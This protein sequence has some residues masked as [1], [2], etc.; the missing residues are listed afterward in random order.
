MTISEDRSR[1]VEVEQSVVLD[2]R[3][4]LERRLGENDIAEA[5]R[6]EDRQLGRVVI[7][8][9]LHPELRADPLVL[10][11][12]R[13]E[14]LAAAQL[15][16]GHVAG[17]FDVAVHDDVA[18]TVGEY[19]DGPSLVRL[20]DDGPL[21]PAVVAAVGH[22][23]ASGLA[24]AHEEGIIHRD[25]RPGNLLVGRDGRV[26]IVDFGSARIPD[27]EHPSLTGRALAAESYL[28]PE[29]ATGALSTDRS[30]VYALGRTLLKA[31]DGMHD[32]P[33]DEDGLLDRV[34]GSIPGL[35]LGT[36]DGDR[37]R[38]EIAAAMAPD[39]ARRPTA[40]AFADALGRLYGTRGDEVLRRMIADVG[41]DDYGPWL[42]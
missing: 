40:A 32:V 39:P 24:A 29:L 11:R 3:F 17:I 41:E 12:F 14:A 6:A 15:N 33:D 19:V 28:A 38:E 23:A 31:L 20:M 7:V 34:L 26:R 13:L 22:Q 35:P 2:D 36:S 27:P 10:E 1:A 16:H 5:W 18:Y 4:R 25:V 37:L 9:V 42:G 8:C 30:D 21:E